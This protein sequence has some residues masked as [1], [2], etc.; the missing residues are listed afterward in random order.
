MVASNIL[1]RPKRKIYKDA[2]SK[3]M[4]RGGG[5]LMSGPKPPVFYRKIEFS[6]SRRS[7]WSLP[8]NRR[9]IEFDDQRSFL[10]ERNPRMNQNRS[11]IMHRN[12]K[13]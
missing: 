1:G 3:S 9:E 6:E 2:R 12:Y 7:K 5:G 8:D 4:D 10:S 11:V 13:R